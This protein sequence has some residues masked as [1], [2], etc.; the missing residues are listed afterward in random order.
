MVRATSSGCVNRRLGF[1][2]RA[3]SRIFSNPGIWRS[4]GVSVTPANRGVPSGTAKRSPVKRKSRIWRTAPTELFVYSD[5]FQ[6]LRDGQQRLG[7]AATEGR[8][9]GGGRIAG[10]GGRAALVRKGD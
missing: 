3:V 8:P 5:G 2:R 4:A 1:L 10:A 9:D 7:R 6:Q